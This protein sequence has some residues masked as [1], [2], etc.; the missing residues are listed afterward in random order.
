[1]AKKLMKYIGGS[2]GIIALVILTDI[3]IISIAGFAMLMDVGDHILYRNSVR[4]KAEMFQM[5][6]EHQEEY[7][8]LVDGMLDI[9]EESGKDSIYIDGRRE[10]KLNGLESRL[11]KKY[12]LYSIS[13]KNVNNNTEVI[14]HFKF[15]PKPNSSWGIYYTQDGEPSPWGSVGE[16]V[17][18]D[19]IYKEKGNYYKYE[20]E[21]ITGKWYY[22]QCFTR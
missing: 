20:T 15:P 4:T 14:F 9:L 19:G 2:L 11:F 18:E 3:L 13:A 6:N 8:T 21:M 17:E 7:E 5:L 22:Y 12:P 1:M 10:Y 16:L